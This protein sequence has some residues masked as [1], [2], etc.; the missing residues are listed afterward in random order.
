MSMLHE[1]VMHQKPKSKL[2]QVGSVR[3]LEQ[4]RDSPT[5]ALKMTEQYQMDESMLTYTPQHLPFF[6]YYW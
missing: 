1:G 3:G 2:G 5:G 4:R 6:L